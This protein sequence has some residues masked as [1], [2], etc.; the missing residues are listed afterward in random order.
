MKA[1]KEKRIGLRSLWRRGLVILSL[2]ALVFVSCG[3][4]SSEEDLPPVVVKKETET[5][6]AVWNNK[7]KQYEGTRVDLT[8]LEVTVTYTDGSKDVLT[9]ANTKFKV[10]P[11]VVQGI[12]VRSLGGSS[13]TA[14]AGV[15]DY[16]ISCAAGD[17]AY[18]ESWN[19]TVV[20]IER[21]TNS[22]NTSW[23][24]T[25]VYVA[26]A[27]AYY[28]PNY[29]TYVLPSTEGYVLNSAL[30]LVGNLNNEIYVDDDVPQILGGGFRLQA[31]Y[32]DLTKKE[33]PLDEK[34]KN[35]KWVIRTHYSKGKNETGTGD[36]L[37][38]IGKTDL[39]TAQVNNVLASVSIPG[40]AGTG[41]WM[42]SPWNNTSAGLLTAIH[43]YEKVYHVKALDLVSVPTEDN[44]P[45]MFY[46]ETDDST[47]WGNRL[48]GAGVELKVTYTNET[49]KNISIAKAIELGMIWWNAN[50]ASGTMEETDT[51]GIYGVRQ[52]DSIL[53]NKAKRTYQKILEPQVR[54]NYRGATVDV[55]VD[56]YTKLD[57]IEAVYK[58][59]V[60]EFEVDMKWDDNDIAGR[61][62]KW[63]S[64][65]IDVTAVFVSTRTGET[66]N[67][68]LKFDE[69]KFSAPGNTGAVL[70]SANA[71]ALKFV[72][73]SEAKGVTGYYSMDFGKPAWP[74]WNS[75]T[76]VYDW[77]DAW[78]YS[79]LPV[80]ARRTRYGIAAADSTNTGV[81][82]QGQ[83]AFGLCQNASNN[84]KDKGVTVYYVAPPEIVATDGSGSITGTVKTTPAKAPKLSVMWKNIRKN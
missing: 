20:P 78:T 21:G 1:L 71:P 11:E 25:A 53:T 48:K 73:S 43:P 13:Y 45:S 18:S 24:T 9:P 4:S 54:I 52:T 84:G 51:F 80:E 83:A 64:E 5:I 26:N 67:L 23:V 33:I 6:K 32:A 44:L 75:G 59:D 79:G 46:W 57:H 61:D 72:D 27:S 40:Q 29:Q 60:T 35:I 66:K 42:L 12:I 49:T 65:Q 16:T 19:F 70:P 7:P 10:V 50:P 68:P 37:V 8:G 38:S 81:L 56:I 74:K 14:W 76:N 58:G 47:N 28:I 63:Y 30:N 39:T 62:A 36:L 55:P 69:S 82:A 34:N 2:F 22:G 15:R 77:Y 41:S 17:Q 3:D 31:S